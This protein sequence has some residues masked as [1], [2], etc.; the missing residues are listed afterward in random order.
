[1]AVG[2]K[3]ETGCFQTPA[4]IVAKADSDEGNDQEAD[5]AGCNANESR[6]N[7]P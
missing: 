6:G 7:C 1:M 3:P 4:L 5:N 2:Y